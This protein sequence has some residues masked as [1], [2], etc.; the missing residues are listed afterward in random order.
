M[1]ARI[2]GWTVCLLLVALFAVT[3]CNRGGDAGQPTAAPSAAITTAPARPSPSPSP[4][5]EI[6]TVK[7]GDTLSEIA[8]RFDT[9]VEAL[10]EE[11]DLEDPDVLGIG[12][13]L[14]IPP[15]DEPAAKDEEP[16]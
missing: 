9:T 2:S 16:T 7:S 3:G 10:V 11:N 5:D 13:K 1:V 12:D 8:Q 4:E 14:V 15:D 6:Y